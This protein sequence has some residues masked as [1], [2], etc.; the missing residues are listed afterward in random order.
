MKAT[1][2]EEQRDKIVNEYISEKLKQ[3]DLV[4]RY[5]TNSGVISYILKVRNTPSNFSRRELQLKYTV[6]D[7]YFDTIDTEDKA[8]FLGLLYADGSV[9]PNKNVVKISLIEPD[10]DILKK[11]SLCINSNRPLAPYQPKKGNCYKNYTLNISSVKIYNDVIKQGCHP[12]KTF[13]LKFPTEE[14]VPSHLIQHF[15]RGYFDGDGCITTKGHSE[16]YKNK[17]YKVCIVSTLDFCIELSKLTNGQLRVNNS[18]EIRHKERN[19]CTRQFI[20]SGNKQVKTFLDWLYKDATIYLKRKYDRYQEVLD[21]DYR[22]KNK[23]HDQSV[24]SPIRLTPSESS[25]QQ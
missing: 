19:N 11:F 18:L 20:V 7:N 8:Y 5:N 6:N 12:Q 23:I 21:N 3:K 17:Q 22:I 4:A 10:I 16:R 1:F 25:L 2:N 15:V 24:T 13:T 14:Q 9:I